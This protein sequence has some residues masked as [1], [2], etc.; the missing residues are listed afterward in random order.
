MIENDP[1]KRIS[2]REVIDHLSPLQTPMP[3]QTP[4][5]LSLLQ[6]N[7]KNLLRSTG[8]LSLVYHVETFEGSP[9]AVKRVPRKNCTTKSFEELKRLDHSNI[10]RLLHFDQDDLYK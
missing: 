3:L 8:T 2:L 10:V 1:E 7:S 5:R 4:N 9:L 6:Y